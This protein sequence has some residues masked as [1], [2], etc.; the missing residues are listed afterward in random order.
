MALDRPGSDALAFQA[1]VEPILIFC[2]SL[3]CADLEV[4][5]RRDVSRS[6]ERRGAES[7]F[8]RGPTRSDGFGPVIPECGGRPAP[9]RHFG[10][11]DAL[12]P[13]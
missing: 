1:A 12:L 11:S 9:F 7:R 6:G 13:I 3:I 10:L 4:G 8:D 5:S 2:R